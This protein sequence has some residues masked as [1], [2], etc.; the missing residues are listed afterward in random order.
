MNKLILATLTLLFLLALTP[1]AKADSTWI[2]GTV[3]SSPQSMSFGLSVWVF[4]F[5]VESSSGTLSGN[6]TCL[7]LTFGNSEPHMNDHYNFTGMSLEA[8][9]TI[10]FNAFFVTG[11]NTNNETVNGNETSGNEWIT[12]LQTI[13]DVISGIGKQIV[14]SIVAVCEMVKFPVPDYVIAFVLLG[15]TGLLGWIRVHW[16]VSLLSFAVGLTV[17]CY[18][19]QTYLQLLLGITI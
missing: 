12:G 9:D 5:N 8:N 17:M 14:T 18:V 13:F 6:V 10:P 3:T 1:L 15:I 2:D 11:V 19:V 7:M 4:D 16:A